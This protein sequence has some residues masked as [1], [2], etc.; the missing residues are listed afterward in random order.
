MS[1]FGR[2]FGNEEN[3]GGKLGDLLRVLTTDM[4]LSPEQVNKI[5]AYF[6]EYREKRKEIKT[7]GGEKDSIKNAR[8]EMINKMKTLL[9]ATQ[10]RTFENNREKYNKILR[11]T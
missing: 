6:N 11:S 10:I 7:A 1:F 2:I 8:H 5:H 9:S 3:K 4:M